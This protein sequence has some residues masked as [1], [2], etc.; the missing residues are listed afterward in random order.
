MVAV[1]SSGMLESLDSSSEQGIIMTALASGI[2][3]DEIKLMD[4]DGNE[5]VSFTAAKAYDSV[6]ISTEKLSEGETYTLVTGENKITIEMS[7]MIYFN[8]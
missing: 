2:S 1:G 3:G 7:D 6:V 5:L 4:S 8:I